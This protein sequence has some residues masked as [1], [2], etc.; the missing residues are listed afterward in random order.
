MISAYFWILQPAR[1]DGLE[2]GYFLSRDYDHLIPRKLNGGLF[3]KHA[4]AHPTA[5]EKGAPTYSTVRKALARLARREFF[6]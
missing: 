6:G 4:S 3:H 1:H 2:L 5:H